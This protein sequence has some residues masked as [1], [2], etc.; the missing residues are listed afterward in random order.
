MPFTRRPCRRFPVQ[1]SVLDNRTDTN[2]AQE[3]LNGSY[4]GL[5][6]LVR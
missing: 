5:S 3:V 2:L 4:K 6:Y 1:C